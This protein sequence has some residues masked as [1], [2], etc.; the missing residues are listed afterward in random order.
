M[1][2]VNLSEPEKVAI[3]QELIVLKLTLLGCIS[4]ALVGWGVF[5]FYKHQITAKIQPQVT[6]Q[7]E[8]VTIPQTQSQPPL[9]I[10]KKPQKP[11]EIEEGSAAWFCIQNNGGSDC[12]DR[13]R[14]APNYRVVSPPKRVKTY[15]DYLIQ[16]GVRESGGCG[17]YF[18]GKPNC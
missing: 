2:S 6:A 8:K 10:T 1:N 5:T 15:E 16:Y 18:N 4:L 9:I 3:A 14:F 11:I 7:P 12:L 13:D 17:K